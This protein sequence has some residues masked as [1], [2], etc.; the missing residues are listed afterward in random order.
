MSTP[1]IEL[2]VP[3]DAASV[4]VV[5]TS[6]ASL[7]SRHDF[8]LDRLEDLRLATNEACALLLDLTSEDTAALTAIVVSPATGT[9]RVTLR[10]RGSSSTLPGPESF[11]WMVLN[12]LVDDLTV[13]D[14]DGEVHLVLTATSGTDLA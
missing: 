5:R 4:S 2:R 7:A 12:A 9:L 11:A 8:T 6:V 3:P 13:L 10:R 1:L 14:S